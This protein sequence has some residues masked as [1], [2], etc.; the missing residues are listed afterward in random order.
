MQSWERCRPGGEWMGKGFT[1]KHAGETPAL[2]G[3]IFQAAGTNR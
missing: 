2:P 3:G 1:A